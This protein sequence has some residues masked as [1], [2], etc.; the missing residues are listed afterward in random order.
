MWAAAFSLVT[1][2][3]GEFVRGEQ[4][5]EHSGCASCHAPHIRVMQEGENRGMETPPRSRILTR[6]RTL[7]AI[8][9]DREARQ[10][11]KT[12]RHS[13]DGQTCHFYR[14]FAAEYLRIHKL[15]EEGNAA[16]PMPSWAQRTVTKLENLP[17]SDDV[18]EVIN[19]LLVAEGLMLDKNTISRWRTV[20]SACAADADKT[21]DS[22]FT[23]NVAMPQSIVL[24]SDKTRRSEIFARLT[25][26]DTED[27]ALNLAPAVAFL[28]YQNF[29]FNKISYIEDGDLD[30]WVLR[31]A[32]L[33]E[34]FYD[35]QKIL[36]GNRFPNLIYFVLVVDKSVLPYR[37]YFFSKP[38]ETF[39][40]IFS[41]PKRY[42]S[43]LT[44]RNTNA[45][46][47]ASLDGCFECHVSGPLRLRPRRWDA[48]PDLSAEDRRLM[49]SMNQRILSYGPVAT[50]W[51]DNQP[52]LSASEREPLRHEACEGCHSE[53][54]IR[55]PILRYHSKEIVA[56]MN[57]HEGAD[58]YYQYSIPKPNMFLIPR[59]MQTEQPSISQR[60]LAAMPPLLPLTE[61]ENAALFQWLGK[62]K[63]N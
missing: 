11:R 58:G 57:A 1:L 37:G 22:G 38:N 55:G 7:A 49:S 63:S 3:N 60:N 6:L 31:Q 20:S 40:Y 13:D 27:N 28:S 5:F 29:L 25:A 62:I 39:Q 4:L 33:D 36:W 15:I 44:A 10:L 53:K 48:F 8:L 50:D 61:Q 45:F 17:A 42:L 32:A 30:I 18:S 14:D 59:N 51:P 41:N 47:D 54:G 2:A 19:Y 9:Q 23:R 56:L 26:I 52:A 34:I 43:P 24:D 46:E 21:Y 12:E 35:V 16:F